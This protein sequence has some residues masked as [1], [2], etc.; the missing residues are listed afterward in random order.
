MLCRMKEPRYH[1]TIKLTAD[2]YSHVSS[3]CL[4]KGAAALDARRAD[5]A[6]VGVTRDSEKLVTEYPPHPTGKK[7]N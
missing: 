6:P 2:T 3:K 4:A 1:S 7:T 5:L